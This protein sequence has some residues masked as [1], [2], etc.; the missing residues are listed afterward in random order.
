MSLM[1]EKDWTFRRSWLRYTKNVYVLFTFCKL[2]LQFR[3]ADCL[4]S[5]THLTQRLL[6]SPHAANDVPLISKSI[7]LNFWN[8][9]T[10]TN[11]LDGKVDH[12][13]KCQSSCRFEGRRRRCTKSEPRPSCAAWS[14]PSTPARPAAVSSRHWSSLCVAP[15][16]GDKGATR[17]RA[18]LTDCI[19]LSTHWRSRGSGYLQDAQRAAQ[20]LRESRHFCGV[21]LTH[22]AAHERRD[23]RCCQVVEDAVEQQ[24]CHQ[25]LVAAA[26]SWRHAANFTQL[27]LQTE[28]S[29]SCKHLST[30]HA[31]LPFISMTSEAVQ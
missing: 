11:I 19:E 30:S 8:T 2:V 24:L 22:E 27:L 16:P 12:L 5:A 20:L 6:Q 15:F 25:Q 17:L 1:P 28:R 29:V 3:V 31:T 13:R 26:K 9:Q 14:C 4:W 18:P 21:L 23:L 7:R 10:G